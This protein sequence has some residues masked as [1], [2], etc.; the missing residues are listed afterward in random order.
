MQYLGWGFAA[1][2]TP[3]VTLITGGIFFGLSVAFKMGG[4][5]MAL[6]QIGCAAGSVTQVLKPNIIAQPAVYLRNISMH[7]HICVEFPYSDHKC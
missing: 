4:T 2:T 1:A 3:V 6:A 5:G 7:D